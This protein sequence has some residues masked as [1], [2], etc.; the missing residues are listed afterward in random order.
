M[1][2]VSRNNF[3]YQS[4]FEYAKNMQWKG[5]LK[6]YKLNSD[7][8]FGTVQWDAADKLNAKSASSR[9]IWTPEISTGINNFTTSNLTSILNFHF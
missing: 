4:T 5:S 1:S 2:D 3:V 9:N 6:K 8:S 7:G